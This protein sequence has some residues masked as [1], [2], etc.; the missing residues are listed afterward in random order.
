MQGIPN[1]PARRDDRPN[2]KSTDRV[3]QEFEVLDRLAAARSALDA[4]LGGRWAVD[5]DALGQVVA[6]LDAARLHVRAATIT[7]GCDAA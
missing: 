2:L 1:R 7:V 6:L 4:F 3:R 5:E